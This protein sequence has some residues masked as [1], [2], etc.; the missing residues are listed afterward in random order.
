MTVEIID[1]RI[2][3]YLTIE[4]AAERLGISY[5]GLYQKVRRGQIPTL[6]IGYQHFIKEGAEI[7]VR[8]N[9][10]VSW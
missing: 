3:G 5:Q 9:V 6:N 2:V 1:G 4:E 8:R 10:K 7:K